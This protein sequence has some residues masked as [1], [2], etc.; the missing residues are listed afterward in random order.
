MNYRENIKFIILD[1]INIEYFQIP[2]IY[3]KRE[4]YY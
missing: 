2:N 1:E 4:D 3:K